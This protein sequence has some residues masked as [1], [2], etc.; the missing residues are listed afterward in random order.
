MTILNKLEIDVMQVSE[1][2]EA[3]ELAAKYKLPALVVH[4]SLAGEAHIAR[5][6]VRGRFKLITPIDWPKGENFGISKIRG[7]SMD[8]LEADG[9]EILLTPN[10]SEKDTKNEVYVITEF[11]RNHV[12]QQAEIR[13]VL[14]T[15]IHEPEQISKMLSGLV[16]VRTPDLIR[17]D[18]NLKTQVSK[19]NPDIHNNTLARI[20]ELVRYKTKICGNITD[21]KT[22]AACKGVSKFGVSLLQAKSIIKEF[23]Q[24]PA[25][26]LKEI[27]A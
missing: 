19:S 17:N 7:L 25:D 26:E 15:Y 6:R 10:K 9:F 2:D 12:A 20:A 8:A 23:K 14:G 11:I 5:G 13:F 16:G 27:L 21:I 18:I 24:Q 3:S 4:Q 22:M 1:L